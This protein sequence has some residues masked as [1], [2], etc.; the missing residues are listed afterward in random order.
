M[1]LRAKAGILFSYIDD[2]NY[3]KAVL[4]AKEQ[5]FTLYICTN[6]TVQ[7]ESVMLPKSFNTDFDFNK[8]QALSMKK[9]GNKYTFYFNGLMLKSLKL[10]L[11]QGKFGIKAFSS[12]A[13]VGYTAISFS[14]NGS[15]I[16]NGISSGGIYSASSGNGILLVA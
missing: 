10:N 9:D 6:G 3:A 4:D 7:Q 1:K 15:S 2:S 16:S 11:Q 8:L 12:E 5:T 14:S 13:H